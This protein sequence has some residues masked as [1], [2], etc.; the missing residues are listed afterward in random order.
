M[1]KLP[2]GIQSFE[3]MI[4]H[5][6]VYVDKTQYIYDLI[7]NGSYYFLARPRRFG[8]SLLLST[9]E[10]LFSNN[11]VLFQGLWINSSDYEWKAYPVILLSMGGLEY[12]SGA[13][14]RNSL[15]WQLQELGKKQR[16]D[17]KEAPSPQARL[18]ILVEHLYAAGNPVVLLI[19]EY[20]YPINNNLTN[21][22]VAE[23]CRTVLRSFYA[24][25][26][27]LDPY[28]HFVL[29]TGV[30]R[31]T[32]TSIFSG[33]NNLTD[34]SFNGRFAALLG[35]TFQELSLFFSEHVN[36]LSLKKKQ[37]WS[38]TL[39]A[40][41]LWY[42][43]YQ[44]SGDQE[45]KVH[46]PFS[47]LSCLNDKEFENYWFRTGTPSFLLQ[48]IKTK[49]FSPLDFQNISLSRYEI[50]QMDI[51]HISLKTL[52]LQTGYLTI[53]SYDPETQNYQ[54]VFPNREV[55]ISFFS[56]LLNMISSFEINVISDFARNLTH[57]LLEDNLERFFL[58][59]QTFFADI[60]SGIQIP[61]QEKYY[62]SILFVLTKLLGISVEAEVMT[63]IGRI[64]MVIQT[65]NHI[66][67]FEFKVN[68]SAEE[69]LA[70]I[71]EKRYCQKYLTSS[72]QIVLV[73]ASFSLHDRNIIEWAVKDKNSFLL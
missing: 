53:K 71:E 7:N 51:E 43:G 69:A 46:N 59:L 49:Q 2:L 63:N 13:L 10:Q 32:Q 44:F 67:I 66:Y 3:K 60:P 1:K 34:I 52:L 8:K 58:L 72:K 23:E 47:V 24:M 16:I 54:L 36:Q 55:Q 45:V 25:I 11:R 17:L 68:K 19:D 40:I 38:D 37:S 21:P 6:N 18:K 22:V 57:A 61:N 39:E 50:D 29:I 27:E 14:L 12:G 56:Y 33:L 73:G 65:P 26:K 35:Y 20:D 4:E 42:N 62:Q 70:Q 31:F 9:L 5:N 28:L 41:E 30:S 48:I 15:M 64:D